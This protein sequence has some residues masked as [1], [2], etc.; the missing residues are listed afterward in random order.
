MQGLVAECPTAVPFDWNLVKGG[1]GALLRE[2]MVEIVSDKFICIVDE[3]K[4]CKGLG[5]GVCAST[6]SQISQVGFGQCSRLSSSGAV[7]HTLHVLDGA[8][9]GLVLFNDLDVLKSRN[10]PQKRNQQKWQFLFDLSDPPPHVQHPLG[11]WEPLLP[12]ESFACGER[13]MMMKFQFW[14]FLSS[15]KWQTSSGLPMQPLISRGPHQWARG[16]VACRDVVGWKRFQRH[17]VGL[18][19]KGPGNQLPQLRMLSVGNFSGNVRNGR[20]MAGKK[21]LE[22]RFLRGTRGIISRKFEKSFLVVLDS[23]LKISFFVGFPTPPPLLEPSSAA[24]TDGLN[25]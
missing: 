3:S 19:S 2:K 11:G 1:G 15:L 20:E 22:Q 14:Y 7:C 12:E 4:L 21:M 25:A 17:V 16:F 9:N 23:L 10:N 24:S 18:K 6:P 5:P 13:K 8:H